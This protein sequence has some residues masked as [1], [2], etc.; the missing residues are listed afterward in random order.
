MSNIHA[1]YQGQRPVGSGAAV[2]RRTDG[3][4][5]DATAAARAWDCSTHWT[6]RRWGLT[7]EWRCW[8]TSAR[9]SC[10]SASACPSCPSRSS[11]S[12]PGSRLP[13]GST[14]DSSWSP[15]GAQHRSDTPRTHTDAHVRHCLFQA[16]FFGGGEF[17]PP[18]KLT[19]LPQ[20][21]AKSYYMKLSCVLLQF[22]CII[23]VS[24]RI[25][26]GMIMTFQNIPT[27]KY[28]VGHRGLLQVVSEYVNIYGS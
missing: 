19:I 26:S 16:S 14:P 15:C 21:V 6:G 9:R 28:H 4:R 1:K 17:P 5:T 3:G 23:Y 18:P 7:R 8:T 20:T 25:F 27:V 12:S 2:K 24:V 13:R 11:T 10:G 22:L